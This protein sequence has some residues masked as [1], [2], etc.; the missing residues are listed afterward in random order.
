MWLN[1]PTTRS[2]SVPPLRFAYPQL[3]LCSV[4]LTYS[5]HVPLR[6]GLVSSAHAGD[7][8]WINAVAMITPEPKN[9][10]NL[11]EFNQDENSAHKDS[12]STCLCTTFHVRKDRLSPRLARP[13]EQSL[14]VSL[15]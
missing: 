5:V 13:F 3:A 6:H 12:P 10:E 11:P 15:G 14:E 4:A 9:F 7:N 1:H 8:K 2:H